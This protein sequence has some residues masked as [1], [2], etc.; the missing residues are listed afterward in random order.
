MGDHVDVIEYLLEAVRC[1]FF[2]LIK[3]NFCFF[4]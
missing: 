2:S 4:D 3:I 1:F